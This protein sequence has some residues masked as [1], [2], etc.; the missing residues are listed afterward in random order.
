MHA[1]WVFRGRTSCVPQATS[2]QTA[3]RKAAAWREEGGFL[4][5]NSLGPF[6][7]TQGPKGNCQG[8]NVPSASSDECS[9]ALEGAPQL[10]DK[11]RTA[12]RRYSGLPPGA[13]SICRERPHHRRK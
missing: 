5:K 9:L 7:A 1:S 8:L 6:P 11:R 3:A 10:E 13:S 4:G 12:V 2:L